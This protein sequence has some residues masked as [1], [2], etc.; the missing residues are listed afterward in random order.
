MLACLALLV[1]PELA[2]GFAA[3]RLP[4]RLGSSPALS[5]RSLPDAQVRRLL[6]PQGKSRSRNVS[7][8]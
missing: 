6:F 2:L 3:L 1:L 8:V 5:A 7:S 4:I